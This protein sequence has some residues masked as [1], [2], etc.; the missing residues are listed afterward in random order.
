MEQMTVEKEQQEKE[1]EAVIMAKG[2]RIYQ[3]KLHYANAKGNHRGSVKVKVEGRSTT[4]TVVNAPGDSEGPGP[5]SLH[6]GVGRTSATDWEKPNDLT[7]QVL[8][9]FVCAYVCV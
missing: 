3:A 8:F 6:W 2:G 5:I 1:A 7:L 9:L 4:V